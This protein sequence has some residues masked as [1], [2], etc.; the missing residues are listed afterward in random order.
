MHNFVNLL[1]GGTIMF[2]KLMI[3]TIALCITGCTA[4]KITSEETQ[5]TTLPTEV[6]AQDLNSK[7]EDVFGEILRQIDLLQKDPMLMHIV[8]N[9]ELENFIIIN[10]DDITEEDIIENTLSDAQSDA[11][12][13]Y[14]QALSELNSKIVTILTENDFDVVDALTT[15]AN[16]L[17][18]IDHVK[19]HSLEYT[20]TL[21]DDGFVKCSS[22]TTTQYLKSDKVVKDEILDT[23]KQDMEI[24]PLALTI[25]VSNTEKLSE[26]CM[27]GYPYGDDVKFTHIAKYTYTDDDDKSFV[28]EVKDEVFY[29]HCH[30]YN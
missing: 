8:Y 27:H 22:D 26:D 4:S 3:S 24:L 29:V 12:I 17:I 20:L 23:I 19:H 6:L 9:N 13:A 14:H 15:K 11:I 1:V 16:P 18:R 5:V 2:K 21:Y 7:K 10:D 25:T 28:S 30:G